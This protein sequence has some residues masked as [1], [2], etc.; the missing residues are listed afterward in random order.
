M[1]AFR[2]LVRG[3]GPRRHAP[4]KHRAA[5]SFSVLVGLR[6]RSPRP[7]LR[8]SK[9]NNLGTRSTRL[10]ASR[11]RSNTSAL[12]RVAKVPPRHARHQALSRWPLPG[13]PALRP[14]PSLNPTRYGRPPCPCAAPRSSCTARASRPASAVG[15]AQTLGRMASRLVGAARNLLLGGARQCS[16]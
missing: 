14:N 13:L 15:L 5:S 8:G 7:A 3:H 1:P 12:S 10:R 16:N 11:L 6:P 9:G 4:R 2:H